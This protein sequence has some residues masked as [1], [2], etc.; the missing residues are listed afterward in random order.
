MR[1]AA[2]LIFPA[3]LLALLAPLRAEAQDTEATA[4]ALFDSGRK[5]MSEHRYVE[6]CP[7]LAESQ[8]LAPSGGTLINLAECYEHTGQTASAWAA[9]KDAAGRANAAGKAAAE[10][11]ALEHAAALEPSLARLTVTL[12]ARSDVSGLE[13]KRDGVPVGHGELGTALPVDPGT[14]VIEANAPKK[15]PFTIKIEIAAK[16]AD[17]R[18]TVTLE[19]AAEASTPPP[20][21]P[22]GAA[23]TNPAPLAP[24][25][26]TPAES[27]SGLGTQKTIAIVVGA[28]GIVGL[29][30]GGAFGLV[31]KSDNDQALQNC[32]TSTL[33]SPRGL[34]LT[35]D[36]K[37]AA[38]FSTVGFGVGAAA[39]VGGVV[40]WFTA[41]RSGTATTG[42]RATPMVG[43]S[44]AGAAVGGAW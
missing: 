5:L 23:S 31:A 42:V 29:G 9:W 37:N 14:H 36:A 21:G 44:Y 40:L 28:V 10:K 30:V 19:D 13:V 12:D 26:T 35:S 38:T 22:G 20:P 1:L 16:Q 43:R 6:A 33:C 7:K 15:Q 2:R 18:V 24:A 34:S 3:A 41:P 17:A 39:L 32:R 4:T 8:R 25:S 11:N 27:S